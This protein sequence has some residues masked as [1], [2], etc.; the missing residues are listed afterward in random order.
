[1]QPAMTECIMTTATAYAH[2]RMVHEA[3]VR[4]RH[5]RRRAGRVQSAVR[6]AVVAAVLV[7]LAV[8]LTGALKSG[9]E[10]VA[11]RLDAS[12]RTASVR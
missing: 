7:T 8:G 9:T 4:M 3:R 10:Q 12:T 2:D 1:M 6:A 5:L 11:S